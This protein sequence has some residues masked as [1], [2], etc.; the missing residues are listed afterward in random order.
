MYTVKL[1]SKTPTTTPNTNPEQAP[2]TPFSAPATAPRSA[3]IAPIR[4]IIIGL[5][6]MVIFVMSSEGL[7]V[8]TDSFFSKSPVSLLTVK[9]NN[10]RSVLK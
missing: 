6:S 2:E 8:S 10:N 7:G 3:P 5:K 1:A 4:I 9:E